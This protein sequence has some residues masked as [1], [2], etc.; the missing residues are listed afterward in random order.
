[1]QLLFKRSQTTGGFPPGPRFK[2]WA[3]IELLEEE[4]A[5]V[6]RYQLDSSVLIDRPQP[7][8]IR[9]S[10]LIGFAFSIF[11]GVAFVLEFGFPIG[12]FLGISVSIAIAW[13]AYD[14]MRETIYVRDLLHGRYFQCRS[15]IELARTEAWLEMVSAFFR[16]VVETSKHWDGTQ[17]HRIGALSP[18]EAKQIVI[19]G[20]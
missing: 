12:A 3:K 7:G 1:M 10:I 19:Q 2:L 14:R 11:L 8:L 18:E 13:F 6:G 4:H 20:I 16:Q 15:V 9:K 17:T 5:L